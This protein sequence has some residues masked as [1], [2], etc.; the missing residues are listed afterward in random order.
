MQSPLFRPIKI[1]NAL[2]FVFF[3]LVLFS[4]CLALFEIGSDV[5][6]GQVY[7]ILFVHVPVAWC[8]FFWVFWGAF[9][10]ILSLFW[11]NKSSSFDRSSHTA[12]ELGALFSGLV[13]ITGSLWGRPTWGVWWDWDPRLTSSFVM[14]LACAG[15]LI[16]RHFTPDPQTR[17]RHSAIVSIL[18]AVNVPIVYFSVNLWR[19]VHQPQTF[20][21]SSKNASI[22]IVITLLLNLCALFLFSI[23]LYKIRRQSLS[24]QETL[25]MARMKK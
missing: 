23:A 12:M 16:L 21:Q 14:L 20:L 8:S 25:E 24:V 18:S 13:L 11:K 7:R 19:S 9:C 2:F 3:A 6:Q 17:Q 1:W 15:Y 22:D 10:G 5:D 4:W